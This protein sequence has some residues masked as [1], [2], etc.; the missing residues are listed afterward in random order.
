MLNDSIQEDEIT[1]ISTEYIPN[2][3]TPEYAQQILFN[4][5]EG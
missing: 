4:L 2:M 3:G 1:I 5:R